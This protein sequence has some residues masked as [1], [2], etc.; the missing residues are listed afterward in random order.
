[1]KLFGGIVANMESNPRIGAIL[2]AAMLFLSATDLAADTYRWKDK[3][4]NVHY[5]SSVPAE[6]A[7]Q[8]YQVLNKN[9]LV[10]EQVKDTSMSQEARTLKKVEKRKPLIS[11]EMRAIQSDRLLVIQ[12]RS[13]SDIHSALEMEL[14]QMN[15]DSRLIKKSVESTKTAIR[16]NIKQVADQQRSGLAVKADQQSEIDK[17]Y[18][19]MA[20]EEKRLSDMQI[21]EDKIRLR[22]ASELERYRA[23]TSA[24]KE[25]YD[26][27]EN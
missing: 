20:N 2:I 21:R 23:L 16:E 19:R 10:I 8:P 18:V 14:A 6:F 15:Y 4:G 25:A 22:F 12:Y 11:E 3:E 1:M 13:E 17:L 7:N 5:G 24:A 9:G 26:N 27:P